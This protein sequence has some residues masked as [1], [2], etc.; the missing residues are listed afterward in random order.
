MMLDELREIKKEQRV[1]NVRLEALEEQQK[2]T[3]QRLGAIEYMVSLEHREFRNRI[4]ILESLVAE[5]KRFH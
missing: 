1:T 4:E 5:L 3:N 2:I